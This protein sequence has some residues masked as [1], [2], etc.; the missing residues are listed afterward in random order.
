MYFV[1]AW[2]D[3]SMPCSKGLKNS[4]A[5]QVLSM[6]TRTPAARAAWAM[7]GTSWTSNVN[8][9]GDSTNTMRVFGRMRAAISAPMAGS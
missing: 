5:L 4:P 8:E 6:A 2:I 9:P 1:P 7:A 3:R